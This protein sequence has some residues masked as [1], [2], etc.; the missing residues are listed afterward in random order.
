MKCK[1]AKIVLKLGDKTIELSPEEARELRNAL[2]DL[3]GEKQ[4]WPWYP[5]PT[6][7]YPTWRI[8]TTDAPTYGNDY[9]TVTLANTSEGTAQ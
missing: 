5:Y 9:A 1:I 7:Y 2:S 4:V 6:P 8:T 3:I